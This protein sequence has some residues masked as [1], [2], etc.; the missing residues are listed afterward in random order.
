MNKK[1]G[2]GLLFALFGATSYPA[3]S[4]VIAPSATFATPPTGMLQEVFTYLNQARSKPCRCGN[5][6]YPAAAPLK[7]NE[8]LTAA[9][10]KHADWMA[11]ALKLSH[12][13]PARDSRD[14]A[15]RITQ[16]GY[17]WSVVAENIAAGQPTA[18]DV[19]DAWLNS[20]G[21]CQNLMNG[22]IKEVGIGYRYTSDGKY[23]AY[24]VTDFGSPR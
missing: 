4:L 2:L 11:S 10:Q 15:K 8:K 18:R 3:E 22:A 1:Y 9:A 17:V 14:A 23:H 16:E 21:H 13:E 6:V 19:M 5:R 20:P 12:T 24:W 7:Y